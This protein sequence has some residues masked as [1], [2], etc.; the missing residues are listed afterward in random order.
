[1]KN[2]IFTFLFVFFTFF[3]LYSSEKT[4]THS[5]SVYTGSV[6]W[7]QKSPTNLSFGVNYEY[8]PFNKTPLGVGLSGE[9]RG[10][11]DSYGLI[12]IPLYY[13]LF[14]NTKIWLAPSIFIG[15]DKTSETLDYVEPR[16]V[17]ELF[18]MRLGVSTGFNIDW[19]YISP[20]INIGLPVDKVL[21]FV[22]LNFEVRI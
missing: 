7:Y 11:S 15:A 19:L 22:G 1:M 9:Y 20:V 10:G 14:E 18:L 21:L 8:L 12:S 6:L 5:I 17:K 13:H 3:N 16:N 2:T 4:Y